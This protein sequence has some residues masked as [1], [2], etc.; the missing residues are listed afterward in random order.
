MTEKMTTDEMDALIDEA[1][2]TVATA[3]VGKPPEFATALMRAS[4][5]MLA[6]LTSVENA[7]W[8]ADEVSNGLV[9]RST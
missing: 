6:D 2:Q 5:D 3:M 9:A 8:I 1:E 4:M 7:T